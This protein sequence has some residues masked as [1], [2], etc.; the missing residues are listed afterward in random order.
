[1]FCSKTVLAKTTS[2]ALSNLG[3]A[4]SIGLG[5]VT[6]A[7]GVFIFTGAEVPAAFAEALFDAVALAAALR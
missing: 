4:F 7:T 3:A 6:A 5:G 2:G 1:M